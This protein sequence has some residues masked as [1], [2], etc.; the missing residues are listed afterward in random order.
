MTVDLDE[1][2]RTEPRLDGTEWETL[3]GFLDHHRATFA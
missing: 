2:G 1:H 3:T